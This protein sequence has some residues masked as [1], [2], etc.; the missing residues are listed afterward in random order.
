MR[1]I[2]YIIRLAKEVNNP[3]LLLYH[4]FHYANKLVPYSVAKI[5]SRRNEIQ[6]TKQVVT[7]LLVKTADGSNQIVHPDIDI[8]KEGIALI[9]TPY[10]YAM[11]E[12]E[13]PCLFYGKGLSSLDPIL[14]PIDV[15]CKHTQGVHMSDPC[16]VTY[17]NKLLCIYRET[18][19]KDDYIYLKE[20]SIDRNKIEAAERILLLS[21]K[22][23]YVLSP[24]ALINDTDL[25]M[26]HVRTN[27]YTSEF[28]LNKFD[29]KTYQHIKK[30]TITIDNEPKGYYLWHIGMNASDYKKYIEKCSSMRGLFLYIDQNNNR[31]LKLFISE[32]VDAT[33][34]QITKEIIMPECLSHIIKFPYKSCFNPQN[35]KIL[36]SFRDIKSRNRLIE[37]DQ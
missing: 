36:L 4:I 17:G 21:T 10:P 7:D 19:Y 12:Y 31:N 14:C 24:A 15:Q 5:I 37:I 1:Y 22:D 35:G 33:H 9:C 13:N 2:D 16:V 29:L 18:I 3:P 11:E 34:W 25:F 8:Y 20:I 27:K 23:E 26:Y 28:I 6:Y 32:C 30:E